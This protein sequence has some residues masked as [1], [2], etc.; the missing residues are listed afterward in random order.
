MVRIKLLYIILIVIIFMAACSE[1]TSK[2]V[3]PTISV[4]IL[5]QKYFTERIAGDNFRINVLVPRGASPETYEPTP[6]QIQDVANSLIYF[7]IGYI[8][9][10]RTISAN[11]QQQNSDVVFINTAEGMDMI[12]AEIVDHGNHVHLYG[13]DPHTWMTIPG[14]R[15]QLENMLT[16]IIDADPENKDYYK[17]NYNKFLQELDQ[18]H[19]SFTEKFSDTKRKTF[20]VF[21]PVLGYFARDYD[22]TQLAIEQDGKSPTTANMREIIDRAEEENIK[23]VFIQLEFERESAGT[24][25][26]ELGGE[27]IEIDPLNENWLENIKDTAEKLYEALN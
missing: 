15:I 24:V 6:I 1:R 12:A 14:V 17:D 22:L 9:S 11:I 4:S 16:A 27:V 5:P 25:A 19:L 8:E 13:V 2:D 18:L 7:R 21:H 26:R 10:E 3:Q 20:L 23:D